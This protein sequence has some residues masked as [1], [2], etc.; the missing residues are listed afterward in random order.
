MEIAVA[1]MLSRKVAEM[2]PSATIAMAQKAR[3]L[4]AKG[5]DIISLSL[6]E[7][8]FGTPAHIIDAA[9]KALDEGYTKY[10]PVPGHVIYRKA[11]I[12]KFKRDNDLHFDLNQIVVSNG[13]KQSIANVCQAILNEGDEVIIFAPY[14]VSYYEIVKYA[15]GV[16]IVISADIDQ[17]FKV[18]PDQLSRAI[19][20]KT[21][22]ILFSSPC[23]PT[24]SVYT[25][26][27]LEQL[28][29]VIAQHKDLIVISD[30]IYEYINFSGKHASIGAIDSLR[31]RTVTVN[32]MSKG[33]SMTGWRL[34]Y[35]GAPKWIASACEKVQSQVTSGAASFSQIAAAEALLADL[36]PTIEMSKAFEKRKKL[37]LQG[38][39]EIPGLKLNDPK[40]AFYVFP[41]VSEYF[42]KTNG[43]SIIDNADDFCEVLLEEAHVATVSGSA[44]GAD[45]CFRISYAASE[46]ELIEAI[47]RIKNTLA[48]YY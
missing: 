15:D 6:G 42:G 45:N 1:H 25:K 21:K 22:A 24:G 28:A 26:E 30:E 11:I 37:V 35:M 29:N 48:T 12:E 2:K 39:G 43:K 10:T 4:V 18:T 38:L 8:D 34:G 14:W 47:K 33:F 13:A 17:D 23:N 19:N 44:F 36:S 5:Y 27:E 46:E 32:G 3:D 40:G 41:D 31:D 7:P 20:H 16:P 9:K